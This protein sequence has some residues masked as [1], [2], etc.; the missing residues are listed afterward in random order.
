MGTPF[1]DDIPGHQE[2]LSLLRGSADLQR[3]IV[4]VAKDKLQQI[5]DRGSCD[6][7]GGKSREK[8]YTH[9]TNI[10]R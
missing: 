9:C 8:I 10:S 4:A 3:Y 7:V 6:G 2:G 5:S 1:S